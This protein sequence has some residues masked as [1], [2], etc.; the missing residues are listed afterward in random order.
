MT[1]QRYN[2]SKFLSLLNVQQMN[3]EEDCSR[4]IA[5]EVAN[6]R[7]ENVALAHDVFLLDKENYDFKKQMSKLQQDLAQTRVREQ[8]V[9]QDLQKATL[10][11]HQLADELKGVRQAYTSLKQTIPTVQMEEEE[12]NLAHGSQHSVPDDVNKELLQ[13]N[14]SLLIAN[15]TNATQLASYIHQI[16]ELTLTIKKL[17]TTIQDARDEQMEQNKERAPQEDVYTTAPLYPSFADELNSTPVTM[18]ATAANCSEFMT[19]IESMKKQV[20]MLEQ[21]AVDYT[22]EFIQEKQSWISKIVTANTQFSKEKENIKAFY[23][24]QIYVLNEEKRALTAELNS[25][26]NTLK[27]ASRVARGTTKGGRASISKK[28]K[29]TRKYGR[30]K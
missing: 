21:Q 4:K 26:L 24:K 29:T 19:T 28:R 8:Q 10:L 15:Q 20:A 13:Q 18:P 3:T 7:R 6:C 2:K 14:A 30:R 22:A 5:K 16:D 12:E 17:N 9:A 11:N 23:R 27:P 1:T 25:L